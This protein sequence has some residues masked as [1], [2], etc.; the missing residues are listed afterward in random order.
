M[1]NSSEL[2]TKTNDDLDKKVLK[3]RLRIS[4]KNPILEGWS[5]RLITTQKL[6]I[7]KTRYPG[8]LA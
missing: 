2:V 4:K 1:Q 3:T 8:L 5:R 7:L 6:Q